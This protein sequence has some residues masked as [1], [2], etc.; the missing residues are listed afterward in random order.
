MKLSTVK[1]IAILAAIAV[2]IYYLT[3]GAK[4]VSN[5]LTSTGETI[6]STLYD[7]FNPNPVGETLFYT[8]IFPDGSKHAIPSGAVS[9]RQ[10]INSGNGVNYAGDG[11]TYQLWDDAQGQHHAVL[12]Q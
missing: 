5:A 4:S 12:V 1:D 2:A 6:G 8:V 7:W 11:L 10:F 9:N 3:R